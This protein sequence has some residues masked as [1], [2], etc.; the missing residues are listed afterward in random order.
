MVLRSSHG[1]RRRHL[2]PPGTRASRSKHPR[3]GAVSPARAG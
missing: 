3:P 2:G 1:R